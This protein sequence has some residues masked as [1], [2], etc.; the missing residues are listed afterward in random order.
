MHCRLELPRLLQ[1]PRVV[2]AGALDF[3]LV[4]PRGPEA[5][6]TL[7]PLSCHL[8]QKSHVKF[9]QA[10]GPPPPKTFPSDRTDVRT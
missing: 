6:C 10:A 5:E 2:E 9:T 1:H 8:T 3:A 7:E 4:S